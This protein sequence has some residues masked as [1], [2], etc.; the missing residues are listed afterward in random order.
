[1]NAV[2]F[3]FA[4]YIATWVIHVSY[5]GTLV[6]RYKRLRQQMKELGKEK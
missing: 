2:K 5:L 3:L 1:M 6:S 4:A